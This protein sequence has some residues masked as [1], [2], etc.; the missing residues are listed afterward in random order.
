MDKFEPYSTTQRTNI[1]KWTSSF[2]LLY[3]VWESMKI[4]GKNS[5]KKNINNVWK[6]DLTPVWLIL[7]QS[8]NKH[9]KE[10][11]EENVYMEILKHEC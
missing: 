10:I 9:K 6:N 5:S 8:F 2:E 11:K 3:S 4:I 7:W 1:I